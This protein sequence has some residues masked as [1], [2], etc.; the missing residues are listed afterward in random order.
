MRRRDVGLV[1]KLGLAVG[2]SAFFPRTSAA[3]D[4]GGITAVGDLLKL[5]GHT[6]AGVFAGLAYDISLEEDG[7]VRVC[8]R[9]ATA[10]D[11]VTHIVPLGVLGLANV[12]TVGG[13]DRQ[14]LT[15]NPFSL[16]D[17]DVC[18]GEVDGAISVRSSVGRA[19]AE[20]SVSCDPVCVA[21]AVT[22]LHKATAT[23]EIC[24]G[25]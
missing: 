20:V 12:G 8:L 10:V 21:L 4:L 23:T 25:D 14:C 2:I 18:E 3:L 16:H 5:P 11:A 13:G 9:T 7:D 19:W 1:V 24:L 6:R 15:L 22:A 17:H